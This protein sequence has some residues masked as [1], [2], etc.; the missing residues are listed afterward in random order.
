[1]VDLRLLIVAADPLVRAGLTT[2]LN[3]QD[4]LRIVGQI[5]I[6]DS[7]GTEIEIYQPEVILWDMGW[8]PDDSLELLEELELDGGEDGAALIALVPDKEAAMAAW[9]AGIKG[10]VYREAGA[11]RLVAA[12]WAVYQGL[13]AVEPELMI[14]I[15]RAGTGAEPLLVEDLTPREIEVL[16]LLAEGLSN[17]AIARQLNISEHTVKFHVNAIMSKLGA[18][19]RTAAVVQATRLGLIVL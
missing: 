18:E 4:E 5:G 16:R 3:E 19:S 13:M 17:K 8:D 2:L 1:M 10:L 15:A 11:E 6:T 12:V 14:S 7:V 9:T